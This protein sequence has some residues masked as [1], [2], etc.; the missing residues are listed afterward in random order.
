[1][2]EFIKENIKTLKELMENAKN[3]KYNLSYESY[4]KDLKKYEDLLVIVEGFEELKDLIHL[5]PE[6]Y[7]TVI[8]N[9]KESNSI[10]KIIKAINVY[11]P[12]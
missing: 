9:F 6:D 2:T 7:N 11:I 8:I 1:M 3:N 10:D 12:F 5:D 4:E